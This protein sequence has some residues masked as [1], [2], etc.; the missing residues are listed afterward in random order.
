MFPTSYN[1]FN[2]F[3]H[4]LAFTVSRLNGKTKN[5][6]TE[7]GDAFAAIQIEEEEHGGLSYDNG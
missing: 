1:L 7:D 2:M 6:H 3:N 5:T 4:L